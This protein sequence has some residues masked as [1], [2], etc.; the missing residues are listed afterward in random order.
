MLKEKE[1]INYIITRLANLGYFY[2]DED[3][4]LLKERELSEYIDEEIFVES[5]L[6]FNDVSEPIIKEA[7]TKIKNLNTLSL[8]KRNE[9]FHELLMNGI[10]IK[11][12]KNEKRV[13]I[14]NFDNPF[15]NSFEIIKDFKVN[16]TIFDIVIFV[17]GFPFIIVEVKDKLKDVILS[18]WLM[19]IQLKGTWIK[20]NYLMQL[21]LVLL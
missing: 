1:I 20:I 4:N 6:R 2:Q 16:N 8:L 15:K 17:N 18:L 13:R 11:T 14:V 9:E 7:L 21:I 5:L 12:N 19:K 3:N 10:L